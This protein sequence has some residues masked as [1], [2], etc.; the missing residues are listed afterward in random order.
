MTEPIRD[1]LQAEVLPAM[2]A[3]DALRLSTLRTTL[4]AIANAEAV[5]AAHSRAAVGLH[6]NDVARRDLDED[7][8]RAVVAS[9]RDELLDAVDEMVAIGRHDLADDRRRQAAILDAHLA[10]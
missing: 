8:V 3:R 2:K 6:A 7:D 10:C 9:I 4:A 5:D 1:R